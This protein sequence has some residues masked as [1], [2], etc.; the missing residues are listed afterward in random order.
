M[1]RVILLCALFLCS[2]SAPLIYYQSTGEELTELSQQKRIA[3]IGSINMNPEESIWS[4]RAD[5]YLTRF[6]GDIIASCDNNFSSV[7]MKL[8]EEDSVY[9]YNFTT[10]EDIDSSIYVKS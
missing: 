6:S 3:V 4:W 9:S 2:C 7:L 8:V 1:Y 5:D 10:I